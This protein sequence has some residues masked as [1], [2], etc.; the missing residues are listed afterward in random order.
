MDDIVARGS[1]EDW[2]ALRD[3]LIEHPALRDP[4]RR[5]CI[6]RCGDPEALT[7][8]YRVWVAYLDDVAAG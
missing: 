3:V 2:G 5:L 1:W 8:R 7:A 4:L 6:A